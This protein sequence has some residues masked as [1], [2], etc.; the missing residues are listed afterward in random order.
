MQGEKW[1][2]KRIHLKPFANE[3]QTDQSSCHPQ[4]CHFL[5]LNS[6]ST[7]KW[8]KAMACSFI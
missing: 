2:L 8:Q 7:H 1:N 6:N 3:S 5:I 4:L